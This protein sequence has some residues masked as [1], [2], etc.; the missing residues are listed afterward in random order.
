[1]GLTQRPGP[2]A[3]RIAARGAGDHRRLAR[4]RRL[5][6]RDR[7]D[8]SV[9][10][11]RRSRLPDHPG[12]EGAD[13][14]QDRD[15]LGRRPRGRAGA[16]LRRVC[17]SRC[18][19]PW[20]LGRRRGSH[21]ARRRG[22]PAHVRRRRAGSSATTRA[23]CCRRRS[24]SSSWPEQRS[25]SRSWSR[26]HSES[27]SAIFIAAPASRSATSIIGRALP[28]LVLIAAFLTLLG[29]GFVNNMVALA[30]LGSGPILT[31][32]YERH[33]PRRPRRRRSRPRHGHDRATDPPADRAAARDSAALHGHP[34]SPLSRS[35]RP[36]RSPRSRAAAGSA[37]SSS[38]RRAT[39]SRACWE[40]RSA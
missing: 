5:D 39:G 26:S 1:M 27:C 37:T 21:D 32:S 31:N 30:V 29:I 17:S 19:A 11:A 34:R 33:R 9:P 10:P 23:S 16:H 15:L 14:V 22:E 28:S 2:A 24:N 8:R 4:R 7:D 25:G 36:R 6:G 12:A 38:T 20:R 35:S 18:A 40:L 3:G 13:T